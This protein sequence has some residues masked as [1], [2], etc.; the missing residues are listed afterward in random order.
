MSIAE[1]QATISE[2]NVVIAENMQKVYEAGQ[3]SMVDHDK[4]I[5]KSTSGNPVY[6]DDVSEIPHDV[7]ITLTSD[8]ITD[9]SD[10]NVTVCGKYILHTNLQKF[11]LSGVYEIRG[12][13]SLWLERR[14]VSFQGAHISF[15]LGKASDFAGKTLY[16]SIGNEAFANTANS[17]IVLYKNDLSTKISDLA[18]FGTSAN[19]CKATVSSG[20][21]DEMIGARIYLSSITNNYDG[22]LI[23]NIMVKIGDSQIDYEPYKGTTYNANADGTI[24]GVKSISPYMNIYADSDVD[25]S[26]DYH[27]SYGMQT[28]WDRLWDEHQNYGNRKNYAEAFGCYASSSDNTWGNATYKPKYDMYPTSLDRGYRGAKITDLASIHEKQG[29]KLDTSNCTIFN[30]CFSSSTITHLPELS[31]IKSTNGVYRTFE[32]SRVLETID[33]IT[34]PN[35]G[36]TTFDGSFTNAISLKNV[37]FE[38]VIGQSIDFTSSPLSVDSMKSVI[39]CLADYSTENTGVYTIGFSESCWAALEADSTAPDGKTWRNYV[40]TTLG[41]LT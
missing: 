32:G 26:V 3:D 20:Y 38:G 6:L 2:N 18:T 22:M 7:G 31:F 23:E 30:F 17:G 24:D 15:L 8:S 19:F 29:I 25:I 1:K 4:I 34:V 5:P 41:W 36:A 9:F 39:G 40:E 14:A 21:T 16:L 13:N 35:T 12:D 37:L 28:E 27:K 10:V 33:K 11:A